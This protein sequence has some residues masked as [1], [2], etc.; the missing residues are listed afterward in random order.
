[1]WPKN[2]GQGLALGY[3]LSHNKDMTTTR[4]I[5]TTA[6]DIVATGISTQKASAMIRTAGGLTD[7]NW[8]LVRGDVA[9]AKAA[10]AKLSARDDI[11]RAAWVR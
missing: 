5:I 11:M 6:G 1:M 4:T 7:A 8:I 9:T 3:F 2:F 10:C